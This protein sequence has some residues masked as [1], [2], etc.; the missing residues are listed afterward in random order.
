MTDLTFNQ[1]GHRLSKQAAC[2]EPAAYSRQSQ[3]RTRD[4]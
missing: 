1:R 3:R 2:C 4:A